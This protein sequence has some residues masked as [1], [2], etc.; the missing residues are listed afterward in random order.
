MQQPSGF[1]ET[2]A[3]LVC[4][5]EKAI[6]GLEQEPHAW[7]EKLHQDLLQFGFVSSQCVHYLFIY[8]HRNVIMYTL[9]YV[10]DILLTGSSSS[11]LHTL[12]N[13]LNDKFARKKLRI[14]QYFMCIEAQ[15]QTNGSI[16][17]TKKIYS[18]LSR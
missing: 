1:L 12:I 10:D 6:H 11:L 14:P 9:V 7:Y 16:L 5:L 2:N 8:N 13:M 17:L 4:Q 18:G 15:Y 3:T